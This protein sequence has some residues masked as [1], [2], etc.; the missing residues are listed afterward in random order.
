MNLN[1]RLQK[2]LPENLPYSIARTAKAL[3]TGEL[4]KL[5]QDVEQVV[6]DNLAQLFD[7]QKQ[8]RLAKNGSDNENG[9]AY[10]FWS[11]L[12]DWSILSE[13]AKLKKYNE[14]ACHELNLF[15]YFRDRPFF[16]SFVRQFLSCKIQ[17]NFVDYFLLEF[18][19]EKSS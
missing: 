19:A 2:S 9:S 17:K 18:S 7:L 1:I 12:K 15:I 10:E 11:F 8:L 5:P 16:E 14:F 4:L 3:R 6:V 13:E